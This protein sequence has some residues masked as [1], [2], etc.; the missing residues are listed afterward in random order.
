MQW[1]NQ[2]KVF[3]V[4]KYIV[5]AIKC[6]PYFIPQQHHS[7]SVAEQVGM[8]CTFSHP[9]ITRIYEKTDHFAL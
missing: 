8:T 1:R 7:K 2:K 6:H 3:M 5:F 9:Y 4:E